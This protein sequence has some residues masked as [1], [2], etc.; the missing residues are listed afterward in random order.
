MYG[1]FALVV[2]VDNEIEHVAVFG[3]YRNELLAAFLAAADI[4]NEGHISVRREGVTVAARFSHISK[5]TA[6]HIKQPRQHIEIK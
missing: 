5:H 6:E 1:I 4:V 3:L 2:T